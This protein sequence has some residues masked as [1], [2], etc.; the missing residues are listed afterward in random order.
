MHAGCGVDDRRTRPGRP[1]NASG[2]LA[3]VQHAAASAAWSNDFWIDPGSNRGQ[4][5]LDPG[6]NPW[7]DPASA[8]DAGGNL[9]R[10]SHLRAL[11]WTWRGQ[12]A[13]AVT[14]ARA[15]GIDD[16]EVYAYGH[17]RRR[18][19]KVST[20]LVVGGEA[21]VVVSRRRLRQSRPR[22]HWSFP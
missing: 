15:G 13:R 17:D 4:P 8:F 21:P 22:R 5:A 12:L 18:V 7:T 2:N 11:D 9:R 10:L 14:V 19:R 16:G 3:R 20:R 6:G 1:R